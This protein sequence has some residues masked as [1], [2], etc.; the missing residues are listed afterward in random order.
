MSY[1]ISVDKIKLCDDFGVNVDIDFHNE[2]IYKKF[3]L[4]LLSNYIIQITPTIMWEH[5][6]VKTLEKF[7]E[8]HTELKDELQTI[9]NNLD[10]EEI[11]K[12]VRMILPLPFKDGEE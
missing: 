10:K 5:M 2:T 12:E 8:N 11:V 9:L 4:Q 6:R 3:I 1:K 7:L